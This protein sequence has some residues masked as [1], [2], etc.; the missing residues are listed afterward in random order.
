MQLN[1]VSVCKAIDRL[2]RIK[3]REIEFN[4]MKTRSLTRTTEEQQNL[5]KFI[6]VPITRMYRAENL[7]Y[8]TGHAYFYNRL[9]YLI[10]QKL[11]Y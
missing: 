3:A 6:E 1:L 4:G 8:E 9:K 5:F 10:I 7:L 11:G 2:R